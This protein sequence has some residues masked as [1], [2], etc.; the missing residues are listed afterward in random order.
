LADNLLAFAFDVQEMLSR[1][2]LEVQGEHLGNPKPGVKKNKESGM[3]PK[4]KLVL[5]FLGDEQGFGGSS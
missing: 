2:L 3:V 5:S 4:R 1:V